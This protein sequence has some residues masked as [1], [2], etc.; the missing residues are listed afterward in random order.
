[1]PAYVM[2]MSVNN[3]ISNLERASTNYD[4]ASLYPRVSSESSMRVLYLVDTL[5]VGGTETQLVETALR[6][7]CPSCR[8]TVGCLRAEGPLLE[9]LQQAGIPVIEFRKGKTLLSVN[10]V[11][12]LLRLTWFLRRGRFHVVHAYDL[13]ANLLGVPAAWL[14]RT[15]TIISSRRYL[16]DLD[17]YSFW[18]NKIVRALYSL[19]SRVVVNSLTVRNL[20]VK[21]DGIPLHKIEVVYNAVNV[22]RFASA[23][24]DRVGL[25]PGIRSRSKV[26]GVLANMFRVKGHNHL[27]TAAHAVCSIFPETVFLLIGD[28]PERSKLEQY[29]KALGLEKNVLFLGYRKDTPELLACC[30]LS[31]LPS[32]SEG[33]PN[34]LLESMAAGLPVVATSVGGNPEIIEDG[35]N[36]LLVPPKDPR[37]LS[38]SILRVLKDSE[39]ARRLARAGQERMRAE[40]SFDRLIAEL[41]QLYGRRFDA[42]PRCVQSLH[43]PSAIQDQTII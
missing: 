36:G 3:N 10:G 43:S 12:Q 39:L 27:I 38:S 1:M 13:W 30:D 22:D 11:R 4:V 5:N 40:F 6:L 21:R 17:W 9:V 25:L 35:V 37:A 8:V 24:R 42:V 31:V 18:R 20:L 32:E 33:F 23:R 34:S 7:N 28:G 16:A 41:K 2:T 19:S 15:P 26:I 29:V 14:A